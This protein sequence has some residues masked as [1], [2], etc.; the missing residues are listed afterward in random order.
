MYACDATV[1]KA[2]EAKIVEETP[3]R[4]TVSIEGKW[5]MSFSKTGEAS[6]KMVE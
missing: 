4:V 2:P 1:E 3:D 6:F 5:K